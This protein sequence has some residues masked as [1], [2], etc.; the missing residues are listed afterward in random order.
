MQDFLMQKY[1]NPQVKLNYK[2]S[3]MK[4]IYSIWIYLVD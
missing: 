1:I 2:C 3:N 4:K